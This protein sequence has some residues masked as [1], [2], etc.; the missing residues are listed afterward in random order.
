VGA[1]GS[2]SLSKNF[3]FVSSFKEFSS[4]YFLTLVNKKKGASAAIINEIS[5][6]GIEN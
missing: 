2:V 4:S 6:A 3:F 1:L 5:R